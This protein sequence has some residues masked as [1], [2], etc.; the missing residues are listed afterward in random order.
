[1]VVVI[2][3]R[4]PTATRKRCLGQEGCLGME[5]LGFVHAHLF[6]G[7]GRLQP[8]FTQQVIA[9]GAELCI[10]PKNTWRYW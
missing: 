10:L 2:N 6:N 8:S 1:M 7:I 3:I 5:A 4:N 9:P